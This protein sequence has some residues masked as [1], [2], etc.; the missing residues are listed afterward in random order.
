MS[1]GAELKT[2][3]FYHKVLTQGAWP[4]DTLEANRRLI[5]FFE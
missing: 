3:L 2:R 4:F 5:R 1:G